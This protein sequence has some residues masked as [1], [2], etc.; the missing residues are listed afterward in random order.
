MN[1]KQGE[2]QQNQNNKLKDTLR[3]PSG[4]GSNIANITDNRLELRF[5]CNAEHLRCSVQC[6]Q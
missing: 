1:H 6:N 3:E 5:L 2:Q 4:L